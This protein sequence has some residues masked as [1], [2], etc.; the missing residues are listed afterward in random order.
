MM[1]AL[2]LTRWGTDDANGAADDPDAPGVLTALG[3]RRNRGGQAQVGPGN[4][5][6]PGRTD[7]D[8]ASQCH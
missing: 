5:Q 2:T 4:T 7:S 6:G 3:V 8:Q 1:R